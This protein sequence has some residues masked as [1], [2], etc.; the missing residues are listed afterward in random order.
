MTGFIY[1]IRA[2]EFVKIGFSKN[3]K[4]RLRHL[5]TTSP[6]ELTI[7]AV[8]S[9]TKG[10]ETALHK[11][12]GE[13]HCHGEWFRWHPDVEQIARLGLPHFDLPPPRPEQP[14][15]EPVRRAIELAGSQR[16][17]AAQI[18]LSQ[19]GISWLLNEAPQV[20]AEIAIA[21]HRA[22]GGKVSKEELRPDI[23]DIGGG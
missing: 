9:G 17:L 15:R 5:A 23:F 16:A 7:A 10:D 3:P 22:T 6:F 2:R 18:G 14:F 19:Q 21:I 13:H 1:F 12:L 8:H 11:W 4:K 20:S